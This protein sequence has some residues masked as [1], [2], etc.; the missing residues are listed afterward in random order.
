MGSGEF[1]MRMRVELYAKKRA[2]SQI[3]ICKTAWL[4]M[5]S[6]FIYVYFVD[7]SDAVKANSALQEDMKSQMSDDLLAF[8][9]LAFFKIIWS[10][11]KKPNIWFDLCNWKPTSIITYY[12][13][14]W[15]RTLKWEFG[16]S[17]QPKF[18]KKTIWQSFCFHSS[19]Y[20]VFFLLV[21]ISFLS[22][23]RNVNV[24]ELTIR[25]WN[26]MWWTW[27]GSYRGC[28]G[29]GGSTGTSC[30]E[31]W[32]GKIHSPRVGWFWQ[33]FQGCEE[34]NHT[35]IQL[36]AKKSYEFAWNCK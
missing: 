11:R 17:N 18:Q 7:N 24:Y 2:D 19:S 6:A 30:H 27:R 1:E 21:K 9:L 33:T 13:R 10:Q 12:R 29:D 34:T 16:H 36:G 15:K 31:T 20:I 32:D 26:M 5:W 28:S 23:S 25:T 14:L 4:K 3:E 35:W 22:N 8:I